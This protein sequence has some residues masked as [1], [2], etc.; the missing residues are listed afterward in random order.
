MFSQELTGAGAGG[1]RAEMVREAHEPPR[2]CS[3]VE[4]EPLSLEGIWMWETGARRLLP[5]VAAG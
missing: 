5:E 3:C 2:V 1:L 4:A